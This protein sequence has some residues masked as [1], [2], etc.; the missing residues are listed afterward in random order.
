LYST[1]DGMNAAIG[2]LRDPSSR[3]KKN[4]IYFCFFVVF[5]FALR[6]RVERTRQI[7]VSMRPPKRPNLDEP[8]RSIWIDAVG[9]APYAAA[10][11]TVV[12][13]SCHCCRNGSVELVNAWLRS[14][15]RG[16]AVEPVNACSEVRSEGLR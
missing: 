10:I 6:L 15:K 12:A 11:P 8:T 3:S 14:Q 13:F 9:D 5:N 4:L 2:V 1:D 7:H 16:A